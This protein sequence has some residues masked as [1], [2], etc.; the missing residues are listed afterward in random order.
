MAPTWVFFTIPRT[1]D[2]LSVSDDE[3]ILRINIF[4]WG[5]RTNREGM[6]L[7]NLG[8]LETCAV[9]IHLMTISVDTARLIR[10]ECFIIKAICWL[11]MQTH[12]KKQQQCCSVGRAMNFIYPC[13]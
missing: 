5:K 1:L 9:T 4:K 3:G 8:V 6:A 12:L 2:F 11:N 13:N 7:K 10:H